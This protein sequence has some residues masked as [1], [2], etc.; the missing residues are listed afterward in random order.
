[1]VTAVSINRSAKERNSAWSSQCRDFYFPLLFTR[2]GQRSRLLRILVPPYLNI[3]IGSSGLLSVCSAVAAVH[4]HRDCRGA[5][6][7]RP[8]ERC[9]RAGS[10]WVTPCL[11]SLLFLLAGCLTPAR[12]SVHEGGVVNRRRRASCGRLGPPGR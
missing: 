3:S 5:E 7:I 1:M 8:R 10:S 9:R 4:S 6:R 12:L 11:A 2:R